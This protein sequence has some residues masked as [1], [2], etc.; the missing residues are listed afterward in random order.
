MND[1]LLLVRSCEN[2]TPEQVVCGIFTFP[3][4]HFPIVCQNA[5][6]EGAEEF[7]SL[8]SQ[9]HFS[10][11]CLHYVELQD[12]LGLCQLRLNFYHVPA[13]VPPALSCI[14]SIEVVGCT[15]AKGT[16]DS[17]DCHI[18]FVSPWQS[19]ITFVWLSFHVYKM[20]MTSRIVPRIQCDNSCEIF[21]IA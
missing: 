11:L 7:V 18:Q 10:S 13:L 12:T 15:L 4:S 6:S 9:L 21:S 16:D 2:V 17:D 1:S 20:G 3:S 8:R 14:K 19:F 5:N